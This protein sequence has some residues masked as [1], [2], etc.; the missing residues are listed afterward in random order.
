MPTPQPVTERTLTWEIDGKTV[1]IAIV[2]LN[3]EGQVESASYL[4]DY[5][6]HEPPFQD[7]MDHYGLETYVMP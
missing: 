2:G 4:N 7:V 5:T 6:G 3:A 1:E